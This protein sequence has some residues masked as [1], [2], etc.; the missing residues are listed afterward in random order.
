M[1]VITEPEAAATE[2]QVPSIYEAIGGRPSVKAAVDGL[3]VRLFGDPELSRYFPAGVSD[4]HRAYL[5]TLLGGALGGPERYRGPD[6]AAAHRHLRISDRAGRA[7]CTARSDGPDHRDCGQPQAAHCDRLIRTRVPESE[8]VMVFRRQA[9]MLDA[10][11]LRC[12]GGRSSAGGRTS[13]C[14]SRPCPPGGTTAW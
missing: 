8:V 3:Y 7:R 2:A 9:A 13:K 11:Q 10:W 14:S 12:S 6:L 1:S 4:R 5:V